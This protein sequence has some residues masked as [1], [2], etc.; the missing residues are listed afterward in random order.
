[1]FSKVYKY[2]FLCTFL[3][4]IL[5]LFKLSTGQKTCWIY[6]I[7]LFCYFQISIIQLS[8][9]LSLYTQ[10][11]HGKEKTNRW[12]GKTNDQE[13]A[14][15][16]VITYHPIIPISKS[17]RKKKQKKQ[18]QK[19]KKHRYKFLVVKEFK[20]KQRYQRCALLC[21]NLVHQFLG[22][23]IKTKQFWEI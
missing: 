22:H 3:H 21:P 15:V 7:S 23:T 20:S 14:I 8:Y 18:K 12:R 2:H 11:K 4:Q 13:L 10:Q 6:I 16:E 17:I 19:K 1:M 9:I 5:K